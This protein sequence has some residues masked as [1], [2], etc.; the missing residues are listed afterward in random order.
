M[1]MRNI[2]YITVAAVLLGACSMPRALVLEEANKHYNNLEYHAAALQYKKYLADNKDSK[3]HTA[4]IRLADCYRHM[5]HFREAEL[6]YGSVIHYKEMDAQQKLNYAHV[7]KHNGKYHE[8]ALWFTEY[9]LENPKDNAVT[10]ELRSCDSLQNYTRYAYQYKVCGSGLSSDNSDF[11]PVFYNNG[12]VFCSDR[13]QTTNAKGISQWTGHTYLDLYFAESIVEIVEPVADM[14][15]KSGP[16]EPS[17]LKKVTRFGA[18]VPLSEEL[19]SN[20]NE[21]PAC[22]SKDGNTIYFTRNLQQKKNVLDLNEEGVDNFEIYTAHFSNGAWS[23]PELL[24]FDNKAYSVGHPALSKDEKRLYFVSDKPGGYGGTDI[25]FSDL[26]NGKWSEPMSVGIDINTNE[27]EMF[28]VI[29]VDEQGKEILYFSSEGHP[30]MGG[31]DMYC[32]EVKGNSFQKP[33]HLNAPLNSSAD[34]FGIIFTPDGTKGFFSTNRGTVEGNDCIMAFE[35]YM[36][37][38]Y[39]EISLVKKGSGEALAEAQVDIADLKKET[40][41]TLIS[42]ADGKIFTKIAQNSQLL[43]NAKKDNFFAAAGNAD[44]VGKE[45]SDTIRM[46]LELE[47]IVINKPIRLDNIYYDYDKWDIRMDATGSLDAL[48]KIMIE[49]PG[50]RIELSSHTDSRGSDTYNQKLS[51]KRAESAVKY[52]VGQGISSDRIYAM[53]YGES[54]LINTCKNK[55]NCNDDEHQVNRR[56]EFKVVK[57]MN[58]VS[59]NK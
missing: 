53:G 46:V 18:P 48:V 43:V 17:T 56:T 42:G 12:I 32:S 4:Q 6:A 23:K 15:K 54:K 50:I 10:N 14:T 36:P 29:R 2:L 25:Y 34:D 51:Q 3:D 41:E 19:N 20:Y 7:L 52:I 21:G 1:Q 9:L 30:G 5:N 57:I 44:N 11:S 8:A 47:A 55:V 16:L 35:K 24:S 27:N 31:L 40:K 39:L 26:E 28:P 38:F 33:V 49:N 45:L 22:F 59:Q 58:D 13:T 37:E